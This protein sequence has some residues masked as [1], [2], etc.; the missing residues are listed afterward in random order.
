LL[1]VCDEPK[2]LLDKMEAYKPEYIEK[3]EVK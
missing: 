3:W 2:D 1:I